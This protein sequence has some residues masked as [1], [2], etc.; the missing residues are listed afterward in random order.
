[1][2]IFATPGKV[3][4]AYL[5]FSGQDKEDQND[6]RG[7]AKGLAIKLLNVPGKKLLPGFEDDPNFDLQFN[8]FPVFISQNET[9]FASGVQAR[10]ELCGGGDRC[11]APFGMKF[12]PNAAVGAMEV[13]NNTVSCQL[14]M[15]H[16]AISPFQFGK[17][18]LPNPAVKYRVFPCTYLPSI[19]LPLP[20]GT[21]RDYLTQDMRTR[22]ATRDYCFDF[23]L[24]FQ[25]NTC[26]HPINDWLT[27]W[28][29]S[30]TP[31]VTV[32]RINIPK[33]DIAD[34]ND[35]TCRHVTINAWR[36][37][38]DHRPLGS[39]NRA[40]LFDL[41]NSHNQRLSLDNLEEPFTRRRH[42]GLQFWT[43]DELGINE[44]F[45]PATLK[46]GFFGNPIDPNYTPTAQSCP[47][48][49]CPPKVG[50][51]RSLVF[52]AVLLVLSLTILF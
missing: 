1:V 11:R 15:P 20:A 2:G 22:L 38:E 10:T 52:S 37:T 42:P 46:A 30:D 5:R 23:Q 7:D 39:L 44:N 49:S 18:T 4:N 8:G 19:G 28:K 29:E 50:S 51:A 33:Q 25:M 40:R 21:T 17:K 47:A 41:M 32:A 35:Y 14:C 12:V 27:E 13:A 43:P 26:Q 3:Y 34:N 16:Y 6:T 48:Q 9:T 31:F 24:Q 45:K 36:V